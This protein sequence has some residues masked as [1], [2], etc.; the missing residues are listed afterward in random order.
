[1]SRSDPCSDCSR[2]HFPVLLRQRNKPG[3]S[4]LHSSCLLPTAPAET[5]A[6]WISFSLSPV[7]S[8]QGTRR[9]LQIAATPLGSHC[10]H[11]VT[12][13]QE[14]KGEEKASKA[15]PTPPGRSCV[16]GGAGA[17]RG[18]HQ[19]STL[20]ASVIQ[21]NDTIPAAGTRQTL[22]AQQQV[23]IGFNCREASPLLRN[24]LLTLHPASQGENQA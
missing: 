16:A 17:G 5:L 10:A 6:R 11:A 14:E 24:C 20:T 22:L 1:M 19:C 2:L 3:W 8:W 18:G 7:K 23:F 9:L 15:K 4:L 21:S 12:G 13:F